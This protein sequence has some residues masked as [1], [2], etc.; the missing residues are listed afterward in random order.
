MPFV[1]LLNS[2]ALDHYYL[3]CKIHTKKSPHRDDGDQWRRKIFFGLLGSPENVAD[4]LRAFNA[5][6]ELGLVVADG[7]LYEGERGWKANREHAARVAGGIGLNL[8]DYPPR[9]VLASMF[10]AR[11][12]ALR[13]LRVLNL[14]ADAFEP[15]RGALDGTMCHAIERLFSIFAA[16][17]GLAIKE[18]AKI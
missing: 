15:E 14:S 10:W 5:D 11:G 18:R 4:I 8:D 13:P 9:F 17:E 6:P 7:E 3:I 16:S 2:G 12:A 1:S